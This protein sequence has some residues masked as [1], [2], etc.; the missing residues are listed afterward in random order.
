VRNKDAREALSQEIREGKYT[1]H[2]NLILVD[3]NVDY[4]GKFK[5]RDR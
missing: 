5:Q 1:I 2:I 4:V 3:G